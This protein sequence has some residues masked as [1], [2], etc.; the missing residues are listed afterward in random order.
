MSPIIILSNINCLAVYLTIAIF[1]YLQ[2]TDNVCNDIVTNY[3]KDDVLA[4]VGRVSMAA[5]VALAFPLQ[6]WPCR[7]ILDSFFFNDN[8]KRMEKI[9]HVIETLSLLIVAYVLSITVSRI[10]VI[11]G[12][13]GAISTIFVNY[14]LPCIFFLRLAERI[15]II[16]K[17]A[18]W[19]VIIIGWFIGVTSTGIQIW[20]LTDKPHQSSNPL[21]QS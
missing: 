15:S 1:G 21:C 7:N 6:L 18:C 3:P 8:D 17:M 19:I 9:R 20:D 10:D 13:T 5:H 16:Q 12:F 14:V 2:F 4:I 11:I